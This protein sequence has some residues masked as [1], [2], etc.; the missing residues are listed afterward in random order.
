MRVPAGVQARP[1]RDRQSM[2]RRPRRRR[3]GG[4]D[5]AAARSSASAATSPPSARRPGRGLADP[6]TDDHRSDRPAPGQTISI[7][8]GGLATSSTAVRRWSH[9]GHTMHHIIDPGTGA[10]AH[11]PW[12]TVSVA[13]ADCADANIATTAALVRGRRAPAWL[14][15]AGAAGAPGGPGRTRY[16]G[17]RLAGPHGPRRR[18]RRRSGHRAR[19]GAVSHARSPPPER[20]PTG[21]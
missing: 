1:R 5:A 14:A 11:A 10:P 13:A 7:H 6:V 3:S 17:R 18:S 4:G 2:G 16:D 21:T 19:G 20:A 8:S 15:A 9:A 12:R